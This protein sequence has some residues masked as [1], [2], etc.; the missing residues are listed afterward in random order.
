MKEPT[1][2]IVKDFWDYMCTHYGTKWK[3]KGD[4]W[5]AKVIA[6]FLDK[7]KIVDKETW[8]RRYSFVLGRTIYTPYRPGEISEEFPAVNQI[9]SCVHEHEHWRDACYK[10]KLKWDWQYLTSGSKR[11]IAEG[12]AYSTNIEVYHWYSNGKILSV[13]QIAK[14]LKN[15]ACTE[16]D[17]KLA[18]IIMM[19]TVISLNS[20]YF[21]P[22]A[23]IALR[24]L[25]RRRRSL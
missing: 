5:E 2:E 22:V 12:K 21:Q 18:K 24:W 25:E 20:G 7:L 1:P 16:E 3:Y 4:A 10:G 6:W 19:R 13:K 23:I 15:Y 17:I 11:A 14:V 8:M 9:S